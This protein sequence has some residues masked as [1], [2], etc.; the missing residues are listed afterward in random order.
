[1]C[2]KGKREGREEGGGDGRGVRGKGRETGV[3]RRGRERV[4]RRG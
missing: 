2:E 4:R 3:R 1:M